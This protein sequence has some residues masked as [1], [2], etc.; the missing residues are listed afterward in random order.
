MINQ[1]FLREIYDNCFKNMSN[2][3]FNNSPIYLTI[4][5]YIYDVYSNLLINAM[6]KYRQTEEERQIIEEVIKSNYEYESNENIKYFCDCNS[7]NNHNNITCN[8]N[9]RYE[10]YI[11]QILWNLKIDNLKVNKENVIKVLEM[12]I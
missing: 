3:E 5:D 9:E 1:D 11:N 6:I 12:V 2:E 7:C 8:D 4:T 10:C